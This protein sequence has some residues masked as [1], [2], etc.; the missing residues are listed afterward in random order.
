MGSASRWRAK[1]TRNRYEGK[2]VLGRLCMEV[3]QQL[4]DHDQAAR[5]GAWIS[6]IRLG[7]LAGR[8]GVLAATHCTP[9]IAT[10]LPSPGFS[11]PRVSSRRQHRCPKY[12]APVT[13]GALDPFGR[14]LP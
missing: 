9:P 2:N 14:L 5:A 8:N 13:K 10:T 1:P 11:K 4:R 7:C 3:C 12:E 6:R